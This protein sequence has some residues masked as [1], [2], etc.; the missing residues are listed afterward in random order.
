VF[1]ADDSLP[2][3]LGQFDSIKGL[4]KHIPSTSGVLNGTMVPNGKHIKSEAA[5]SCSLLYNEF[6]VYNT[7]QIEILYIA[8]VKFEYED[9]LW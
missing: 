6:V 9:D 8:K 5:D 4:G 7:N 3:T 2:K 1:D